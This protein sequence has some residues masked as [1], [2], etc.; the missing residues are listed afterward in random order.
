MNITCDDLAGMMRAAVAHYPELAG[1]HAP[2]GGSVIGKWESGQTVPSAET[3]R[4][5]AR[6][7]SIPVGP[8]LGE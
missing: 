1:Y 7:L 4:I 8:L 3:L 6:V 5:L 2:S